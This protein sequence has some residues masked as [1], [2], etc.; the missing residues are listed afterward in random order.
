MK[1]DHDQFNK[2]YQ[3]RRENKKLVELIAT[4]NSLSHLKKVIS[5]HK[6]FFDQYF[7]FNE[8]LVIANDNNIK[9]FD[10]VIA[11]KLWLDWIKKHEKYL[12]A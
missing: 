9:F 2:E 8:T 7:I 3:I 12:M 5:K 11:S 10:T 6:N 1:W 4:I